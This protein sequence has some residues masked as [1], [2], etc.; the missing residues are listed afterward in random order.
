MKF[1]V[2][3]LLAF[4]VCISAYGHHHHTESIS[5]YNFKTFHEIP[6]KKLDDEVEAKL[7]VLNKML[8][9]YQKEL[10][11]EVKLKSEVQKEEVEVD[12]A[13]KD[14][15]YSYEFGYGVKDPKTGDSKDQWEKSV[16][17]KVKG[18]YKVAES[19]GTVRIVEYEADDK[20]G[21][22]A[23]VTNVAPEIKSE[24]IIKEEEKEPYSY[25]YLKKF[26]Y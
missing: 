15:V 5:E 19:D 11:T 12:E 9:D 23:K 22:E 24:K 16:E 6:E 1:T 3:L 4:V 13:S 7:T 2:V 25:S 10:K 21:F 18:V 17:G 8:K 26:T 20:K 14:K